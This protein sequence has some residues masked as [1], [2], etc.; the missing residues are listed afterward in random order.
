MKFYNMLI[1]LLAITGIILVPY[2]Y[3]TGPS[4]SYTN[5]DFEKQIMKILE[6]NKT[7][8]LKLNT[9]NALFKIYAKNGDYFLVNGTK[10]F[11]F[12]YLERD[13]AVNYD[14]IST[15]PNQ[16]TIVVFPT[17]TSSAYSD[18]GFYS[19]YRKECDSKCL[20]I[21]IK[22]DIVAQ[23][24]PVAVQVLKLLGY[25]FI[26]DTDIDKKPSILKSY[27]KVILLHNEYVTKK[28][29]N[30]ITSHP[31]VIYLYANALYTEVKTDYKKNTVT[32]VKGHGY[33]TNDVSNGFNWKFDNSKFEYN[34]NCKGVS[35]KK[36]DNGWI[37]DCFPRKLLL[38]DRNFLVA[39]RE[40]N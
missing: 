40:L 19:Y 34:Y 4:D 8:F 13:K 37:L 33:P 32:L 22:N 10:V 21:P 25:S 35:F 6:I 20:T 18:K 17:F 12:I 24:S 39:L 29:F 23:T 11:N 7:G 9:T 26:T 2:S 27:D 15:K 36:I 30:A 31:H 38:K 3:A 1:I 5:R 14:D 28:E 16:K